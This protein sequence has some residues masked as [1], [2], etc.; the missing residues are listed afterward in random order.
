MSFTEEDQKNLDCKE[1]IRE[2]KAG[3]EMRLKYQTFMY[4]AL[5]AS[6]TSLTKKALLD[7]ERVFTILFSA[8]A[9]FR[10]PEYRSTL[11][12]LLFQG[13]KDKELIEEI[14]LTNSLI[15][16]GCDP[17]LKPLLD[18]ETNFYLYLRR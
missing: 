11:L 3:I 17:A 5:R 14:G 13:E 8:Q 16:I 10:I 1:A 9:F 15:Y 18:W 12:E 7:N 2:F 4:Q 6:L